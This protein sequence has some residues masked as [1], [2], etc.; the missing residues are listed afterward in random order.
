VV[1]TRHDRFAKEWLK[2]LLSDF[3]EV[4]TERE[5]SGEVR[6]IDLIFSPY[7]DRTTDLQALGLLGR[8]LARPACPIEFFRNAVPAAEI[9][10]CRD[11]GADLRS[12]LRRV[13]DQQGDKIREV[14][15]P[16][17]WIFTP[18]LSEQIQRT[19]QMEQKPE[20][21]DGIYFLPKHDLT[22]IVVIHQ[23]PVTIDTLWIRLLGKGSVQANA[24]RELSALPEDYA[25]RRSTLRHLAI[26]QVS[27]AM[28]QNKSR[29][30]QEVMMNLM[31]AYEQWEAEK[32]A[33]GEERGEKRGRKLGK[34]EGKKEGKKEGLKLGEERKGMEIA[35]RMLERDIPIAEIADLTGL[36]I[37]Q[38]Q[39]L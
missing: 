36:S 38:I 2:E 35:L 26:L 17:L 24:V 9:V 25:Y 39:S 5:V 11:K 13:A 19:F 33:E 18:T 32:L 16:M 1:R 15:L 34:E 7:P 4:K 28:R 21:E 3:G 29:D 6:S 14:D 22:A 8:I 37:A 27:L 20:W 31:P 12:E 10:N 23:L 30:L